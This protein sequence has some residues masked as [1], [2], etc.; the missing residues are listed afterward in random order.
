MGEGEF[1]DDVGNGDGITDFCSGYGFATQHMDWDGDGVG[2][3]VS[4][5]GGG[6]IVQEFGIAILGL[7]IVDGCMIWRVLASIDNVKASYWGV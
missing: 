1:G 2:T 6:V 7:N 5:G 4:N 3:G